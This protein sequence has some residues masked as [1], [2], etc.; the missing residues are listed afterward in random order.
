MQLGKLPQSLITAEEAAKLT[1]DGPDVQLILA[2]AELGNGKT[3]SA[4]QRLEALTKKDPAA[5]GPHLQLAGARI[6][7]GDLRKAAASYQKVLDINAGHLS[8]I[9]GMAN[10]ALLENK[11]GTAM[12]IARELQAANPESADGYA[13][14]G[15]TYMA[16]QQ[17]TAAAKSYEAALKRAPVKR[18]V[19]ALSTAQRRAG[20]IL[21]ADQTLFAWLK[22][23]PNDAVVRA[24]LGNTLSSRDPKAAITQFERV[25]KQTPGNVVVLN[26]LAYLYHQNKDP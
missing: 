4:I 17:Y 8:A 23:N 13:L 15:D 25:I 1:P 6:M 5:V 11:P 12:A 22:A 18:L 21:Q 9:L 3:D 10:V 20:R 14:E 24:T 2:R 16:T 7:Q 19:I 26:N